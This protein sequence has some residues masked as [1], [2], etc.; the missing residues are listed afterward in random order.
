MKQ[1]RKWR[2]VRRAQKYVHLNRNMQLVSVLVRRDGTRS[3]LVGAS[4]EG[5]DAG[6][7]RHRLR[8]DM[9]KPKFQHDLHLEQGVQVLL[10]ANESD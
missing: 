4:S 10:P 8:T 9:W 6:R 5:S 2:N 7:C 3:I 1:S